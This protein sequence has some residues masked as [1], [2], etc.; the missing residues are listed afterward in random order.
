M[1]VIEKNGLYV[2]EGNRENR[3]KPSTIRKDTSIGSVTG[4]KELLGGG[5]FW[6]RLFFS[7]PAGGLNILE[8]S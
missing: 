3:L 7:T 5:E 4:G 6:D 2:Y 1:R 8:E